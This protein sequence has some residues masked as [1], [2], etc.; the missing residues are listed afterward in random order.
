MTEPIVAPDVKAV[1][2]YDLVGIDTGVYQI[3]QNGVK[4]AGPYFGDFVTV[5]T[6]DYADFI[7]WQAKA[8]N[9]QADWQVCECG[10]VTDLGANCPDCVEVTA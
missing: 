1:N 10:R 2:M 8:E 5:L 7:K 9:P 3:E 4:V 6:T